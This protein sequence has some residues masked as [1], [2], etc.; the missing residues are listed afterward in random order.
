LYPEWSS[1]K[2][3]HFVGHSLGATTIWYLQQLLTRG[4]FPDNMM[5][6]DEAPKFVVEKNCD[7][8][9]TEVSVPNERRSGRAGSS[10]AHLFYRAG[11]LT[12]SFS[13]SALVYPFTVVGIVFWLIYLYVYF[14]LSELRLFRGP[15]DFNLD[16]WKLSRSAKNCFASPYA[17]LES[18]LSPA[19]PNTAPES[20]EAPLPA[21]THTRK[22]GQ[23]LALLGF[24]PCPF[25][26]S[27][28]TALFD[29]ALRR[30]ERLN[31]QA[32]MCKRTFYRTFTTSVVRN[33][34]T[35][36]DPVTKRHRPFRARGA[37]LIT[38]FSWLMGRYEVPE[39]VYTDG[40]QQIILDDD[41]D[42]WVEEGDDFV[43]NEDLIVEIALRDS[44]INED[45]DAASRLATGAP[46]RGLWGSARPLVKSACESL[47]RLGQLLVQAIRGDDYTCLSK[48]EN[49]REAKK[50]LSPETVKAPAAQPRRPRPPPLIFSSKPPSVCQATTR[51]VDARGGRMIAEE[52]TTLAFSPD[53]WSPE[54]WW[55]NDGMTPVVSQRHPGACHRGYCRGCPFTSEGLALSLATSHSRIFFPTA[56]IWEAPQN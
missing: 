22:T 42:Q 21:L 23:W 14:D 26:Q 55:E 20:I 50:P 9:V 12:A 35:E 30:M 41:A 36:A 10:E 18:C 39:A 46:Q 28:D 15:W 31:R 17:S 27:R 16:H 33:E 56:N 7:F 24:R 44:Q 48:R 38:L 19:T 8:P 2:P 43:G 34:K 37:S 52:T 51:V 11:H 1:K 29:I 53:P 49:G 3:L 40:N 13:P 5:A 32:V 4:W 45:V 25:A 47:R 6:E 54:S